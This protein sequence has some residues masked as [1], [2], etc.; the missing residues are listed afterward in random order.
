MTAVITRRP[1]SVAAR[2]G[3]SRDAERIRRA[4]EAKPLVAA[5]VSLR[6]T[7]SVGVA[8]KAPHH[9]NI[10]QLIKSGDEALYQAKQNGRNRVE[11]ARP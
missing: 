11:R 3:R 8:E 7:A 1:P 6:L 10:D 2:G 9:A 5:G 4:V